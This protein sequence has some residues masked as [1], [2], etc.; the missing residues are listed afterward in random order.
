ME[1]V[2]KMPENM[3]SMYET[4]LEESKVSRAHTWKYAEFVAC[5]Y[6]EEYKTCSMHAWKS[7]EYLA[8]IPGSM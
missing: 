3:E 6:I 2:C 5:M 1:N 7:E 8:C 4:H